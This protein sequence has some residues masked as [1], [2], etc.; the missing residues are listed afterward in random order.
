MPIRTIVGKL[1]TDEKGWPLIRFSPED[2]SLTAVA[3][4][5]QDDVDVLLPTCD[6]LLHALQSVLAG[7]EDELVWNG[8]R[9]LVRV[10]RDRTS[11][12][13]KYG[14]MIS[15]TAPAAIDTM[16][17]AVLVDGWRE[18]V[19]ELPRQREFAASRSE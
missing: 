16:L 4:F 18:F 3:A 6:E 11:L 5:L 15:Q 8:D 17:L 2:E 19:S 14:E 10:K 9:F 7:K 1:K 13:D 12:T